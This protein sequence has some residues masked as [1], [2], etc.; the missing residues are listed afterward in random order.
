[1]TDRPNAGI[2]ER[3][4]A[5][6]TEPPDADIG[7]RAYHAG[8]LRVGLAALGLAALPGIGIDREVV[9]P[10][11]G[12]Y[13]TVA[14]VL[15]VLLYLRRGGSVRAWA[16]GL[17][18]ITFLTFIIHRVG[19]TSTAL[20]GLYV[21]IPLMYA[22]AGHPKKAKMLGRY[23]VLAFTAML[24]AELAGWLPVS[25]DEPVWAVT[26]P[27]RPVVG[28]LVWICVVALLVLMTTRMVVDLA[29]ALADREQQLLGANARL[30]QMSQRDPLTQLYNRRHLMARMEQGLAQVRRGHGCALVMMDL[31]RFKSINDGLGHLAGDDVLRA[32]A[33]ALD[34]GVRATD[35]AARYGGDEFAVLLSDASPAQ[36]SRVAQRL[37]DAI[38]A[39]GQVDAEHKVTASV[40][41]TLAQPDDDP[42]MLIQ[43]ADANAY[44]AKQGGG[45]RVVGP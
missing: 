3:G 11:V 22:M 32:V 36:V 44:A 5:T 23:G 27:T 2:G 42:K 1:M 24:L 15:Q 28:T 41:V 35:V 9:G 18:D 16:G 6:V 40:G 33:R 13:F 7:A 21:V 12:A 20:T 37:T 34:D 45:N 29:R 26:S 10:V 31:D 38:A 4:H 14:A 25:P 43:R 8:W 19:A 17:A 39:A 30:E